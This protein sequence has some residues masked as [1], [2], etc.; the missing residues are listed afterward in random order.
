MFGCV[1]KKHRMASANRVMRL[2]CR[3]S[4]IGLC[5]RISDGVLERKGELGT[6]IENGLELTGVSGVFCFPHFSLYFFLYCSIAR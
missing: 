4:I 1:G 2:I 5:L 3:D 6:G